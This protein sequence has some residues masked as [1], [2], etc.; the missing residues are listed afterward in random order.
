[1]HDVGLEKPFFL[2]LIFLGFV[3]YV[4]DLK[5]PHLRTQ[6]LDLK[7]GNVC[8]NLRLKNRNVCY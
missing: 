5:I 1:M 7:E 6:I 2:V 4:F 3:V 8:S